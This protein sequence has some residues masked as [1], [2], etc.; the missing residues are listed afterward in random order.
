LTDALSTLLKEDSLYACELEGTRY[1]AGTPLGWLKANI[2][3]GLKHNG[4]G[5]ELK[6]YI[7]HVLK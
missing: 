5:R 7:K 1:D 3:L 6:E 2:S 4:I